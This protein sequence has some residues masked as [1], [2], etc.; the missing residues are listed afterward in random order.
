MVWSAL[1]GT[2]RFLL[3]AAFL[4][5]FAT[6]IWAQGLNPG[7][8]DGQRPHT[9]GQSLMQDDADPSDPAGAEQEQPLGEVGG[10]DIDSD[11]DAPEDANSIMDDSDNTGVLS[12][13]KE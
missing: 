7:D 13:D 8:Q 1:T 12:P 4:L 10:V 6:S 9:K 5:S 3:G 11:P 2:A